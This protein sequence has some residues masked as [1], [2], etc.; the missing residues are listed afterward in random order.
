MN[1]LVIHLRE[2]PSDNFK[3]I[4]GNRLIAFSLV[5][6]LT[7]KNVKT[8]AKVIQCTTAMKK[9]KLKTRRRIPWNKQSKVL[10]LL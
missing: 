10:L 4:D 5:E 3:D 9:R 1:S 7:E 8:D 2:G 6:N